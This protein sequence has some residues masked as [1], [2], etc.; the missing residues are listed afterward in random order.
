M[1]CSE[2]YGFFFVVNT[3]ILIHAVWVQSLAWDDEMVCGM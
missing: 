3:L 2:L 1:E